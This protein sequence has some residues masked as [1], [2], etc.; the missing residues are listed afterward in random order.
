MNY[1]TKESRIRIGLRIR[2][3][4]KQ[5][6]LSHDRLAVA[7]DSSR[8]HLIKLEKGKHVPREDL[9]QRIA[10]ATGKQLSFFTEED[11][12]D[13]ESDPVAELYR[14]LDRF[15]DHKMSARQW[16]RRSAASESGGPG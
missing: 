7:V 11:D 14:A 1:V 10:D 16:D 13:E 2:Q 4:R 9:L 15:I 6:G 3:A 12:D 8:Q 5:A